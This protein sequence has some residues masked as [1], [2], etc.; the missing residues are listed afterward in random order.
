[1]VFLIS[2]AFGEPSFQASFLIFFMH[3]SVFYGKGVYS[4]FARLYTDLVT[5]ARSGCPGRPQMQEKGPA[6]YLFLLACKKNSRHN[7]CRVWCPFWAPV[8]NVLQNKLS[9]FLGMFF[10][11]DF[12][13]DL[14]RGRRRRRESSRCADSADYA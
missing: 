3:V 13:V 8:W 12:C 1:M 7:F 10:F 2:G 6:E 9:C 4:G 11:L 5:F 14:G